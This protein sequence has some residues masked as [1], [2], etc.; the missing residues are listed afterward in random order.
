MSIFLNYISSKQQN[1]K[2]IFEICLCAIHTID[3]LEYLAPYHLACPDASNDGLVL[4]DFGR[5]SNLCGAELLPVLRQLPLD[6]PNDLRQVALLLQHET[7]AGFPAL[8]QKRSDQHC[9]ALQKHCK[10]LQSIAKALQSIALRLQRHV[11]D[12]LFGIERW[13]GILS[14]LF[15]EKTFSVALL[16][17]RGLLN[18]LWAV[19]DLASTSAST[20]EA[21]FP[22]QSKRLRTLERYAQHLS[23][24]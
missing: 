18:P 23:N 11:P 16:I 7:L 6:A 10:A 22:K 5:R 21:D 2:Y 20:V 4:I 24:L 8:L 17:C 19:I 15:L 13:P 12:P 3:Q 14:N 9:T 1:T